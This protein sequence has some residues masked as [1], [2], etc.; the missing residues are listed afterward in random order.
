M[1]T[2]GR[3]ASR[4]RARETERAARYE[5]ATNTGWCE[6]ERDLPLLRQETGSILREM[7]GARKRSPVHWRTFTGDE[8]AKH[9]DLLIGGTS[10]EALLLDYRSVLG[11]LREYGGY[12]ITASADYRPP[13]P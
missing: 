13:E 11:R 9:V 2:P 4:R 8:A 3:A 7:L 6:T 1:S 12:V 10:D 5:T